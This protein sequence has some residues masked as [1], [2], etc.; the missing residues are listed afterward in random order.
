MDNAKITQAGDALVITGATEAQKDRIAQSLKISTGKRPKLITRKQ[1][2]EI[3]GV[4]PESIKRYVRRGFI[5]QINFTS[6]RVRYDEAEIIEFSRTGAGDHVL[7][8]TFNKKKV[9]DASSNQPSTEAE[10]GQ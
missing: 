8:T 7:D 5:R 2:A 9:S 6:R 1:A 4:C 10:V 3:L